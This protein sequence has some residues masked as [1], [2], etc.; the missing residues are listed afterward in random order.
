MELRPELLPPRVSARHIEDLGREIDRIA[1][2]RGDDARAA[3][4][5]FQQATGHDY[6]EFFEYWGAESRE[7]AATRAA[8]PRHPRVPDITRDELV[9]IVHRIR[10]CPP[11]DQDWYVLVLKTNTI[12]PAPTDL[13]FWPS[14]ELESASS[15]EIVDVLLNH[16]PTA[17]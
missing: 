13:I 6:G 17:L 4:A 5:A 11:P 10:T 8:R 12:H 7:A 2:L 14:P 16:R 1:A 15:E 3:M 9:E